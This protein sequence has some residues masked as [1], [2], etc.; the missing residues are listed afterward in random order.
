V[1]AE[2]SRPERLDA[3]GEGERVVEIAADAGERAAV[4]ARFGL[5]AVDRLAATLAIRRDAGGVVVTGRVAAD[6]VQACSV[7][8]DPLT[9][10]V[11]EPVA[12]RFVESL[13]TGEEEIELSADA[14]DTV[15]I[16]GGAI[17]LGEAAAETMALALDPFPRGPGAEA[18]LRDA[19]VL[20]EEEARTQASPFSGL[21]A[22]KATLERG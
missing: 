5:V 8:G 21:A 9:V 3:I 6:L 19:G 7:T 12:L 10:A 14:L 22:L 1:T 17:D 11:D 4:A 15:E 20:S 13:G 18:V 16:E 2:W